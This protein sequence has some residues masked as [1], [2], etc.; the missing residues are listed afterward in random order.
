M[1]NDVALACLVPP[2]KT[3]A[4]LPFAYFRQLFA[5]VTN[6]PIDP[7]REAAVMSLGAWVGPVGNVLTPQQA[8]CRRLWLPQ[9]VLTLQDCAA[10]K[11][12]SEVSEQIPLA[13]SSVV[14]DVTFEKTA[15][16]RGYRLALTRILDQIIEA[17]ARDSAT[18]III[19]SDRACS[20][21]RVPVS[22][23]VAT[24]YVHQALLAR[25]DRGRVA[26][27]VEG[28]EICEIHHFCL[29]LGY[30]ADASKA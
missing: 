15:G 10:L 17:M 3:G 16:V 29:L 5:Q 25:G 7:I 19:L 12:I 1:G 4:P 14:V 24:G 13:W 9:P 2:T 8:N 18:S 6:P 23:L 28:G 26:L 20:A 22:T 11:R 30:G 27:V 21:D